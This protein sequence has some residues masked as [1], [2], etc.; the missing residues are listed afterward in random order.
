MELG[1]LSGTHSFIHIIIDPLL[2]MTM[3]LV[4]LLL[5]I[6]EVLCVDTQLTSPP[7]LLDFSDPD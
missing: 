5:C 7:R 6:A 1:W 4:M 2:M 3:L